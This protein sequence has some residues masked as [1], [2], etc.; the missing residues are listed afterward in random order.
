MEITRMKKG[1]YQVRSDIYV[2]EYS[3]SQDAF[4]HQTLAE[5]MRDNLHHV[6]WGNRSQW[7]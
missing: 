4:H 2:A 7:L 5:A 6:R 3:P 1:I